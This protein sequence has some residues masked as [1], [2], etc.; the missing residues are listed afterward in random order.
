MN[1]WI[2]SYF[3]DTIG[4]PIATWVFNIGVL[5]LN[6]LC[7]GYRFSV[8]FTHLLAG[9]GGGIGSLLDR[10]GGIQ[11]RWEIHFNIT[12]LRLVSYNLDCYWSLKQGEGSAL[13]VGLYELGELE[14]GADVQ[15]KKQTDGVV[16]S[17][18]ERVDTPCGREDYNFFTYLAYALYSPLYLAGPIMTFNDYVAQVHISIHLP[19]PL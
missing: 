10:M 9:E 13:E 15:K 17:E 1:Y 16:L 7:Q 8:I 18:R 19:N 4:G 12:M 11:P 5:F 14:D 3:G 6:E 2:S